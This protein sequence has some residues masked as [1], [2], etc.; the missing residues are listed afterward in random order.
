M[1]VL[2]E[3]KRVMNRISR[4]A[5]A[6]AI[7]TAVHINAGVA[8]ENFAS[9]PVED[10]DMAAAKQK[11]RETLPDFL[12]LAKTPRPT[13]EHLSLKIRIEKGDQKEFFW[14]HPFEQKEGVFSGVVK[15]KPRFVRNVTYGQHIHFTEAEVADWLYI[16]NGRM[17]G[18]YTACA[19]IKR[20]PLEQQEAFKKRHGLD[21]DFLNVSHSTPLMP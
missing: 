4:F 12:V 10:P 11:A 8:E 6:L 16:E 2:I 13:M 1:R 20:E 21:C 7:A 15:S 5:L 18:N 19:V 17:K 9:I 3:A 14:V